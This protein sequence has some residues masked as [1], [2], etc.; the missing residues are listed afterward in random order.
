MIDE[1][2]ATRADGLKV[3]VAVNEAEMT[4]TKVDNGLSL[5]KMYLCQLCGMDLESDISLADENVMP[6]M[7]YAELAEEPGK[8]FSS[9]PELSMLSNSID[10][11]KE[12]T[13]LARAGYLPQLALTGGAVFSN[14]SIYN[15]FERKFK[16]ALTVGVLLRVPVLDWGETAYKIRASKNSTRL[17]ELTYN[18]AEEMISLQVNQCSFKLKEAH[19]H[20]ATALGNIKSAE[21]NLRC[22]NLGFR[23]GVISTTDV[24]S[25]Q[26]A[27]M[28]AQT[29]KIDAEIDVKTAEVAMKKATGKL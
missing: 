26:T 7:T 9:R 4:L 11:A 20:L 1:G 15:G 29:E 27:W 24:M 28:K 10:L 6:E 23:E 13:K 14:P 12:K 21:E 25:A 19:K 8:D 22:A 3:D 17:A 2:V 16:G 5:A 18:E